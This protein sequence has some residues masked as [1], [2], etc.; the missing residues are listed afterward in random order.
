MDLQEA[1]HILEIENI[2][3]VSLEY[4]KKAEETNKWD[5]LKLFSHVQN[6]V[7]GMATEHMRLFGSSGKI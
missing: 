5:P 3:N 4:L 7:A 1:L 2:S 6:A